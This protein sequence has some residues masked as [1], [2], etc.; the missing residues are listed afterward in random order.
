MQ[1]D[2]PIMIIALYDGL[3][4]GITVK[5]QCDLKYFNDN[6]TASKIAHAVHKVIQEQLSKYHL[7][8]NSNIKF[9]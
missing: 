2:N 6:M 4:N 8:V 7:L 9:N 3:D 1:D 5:Y